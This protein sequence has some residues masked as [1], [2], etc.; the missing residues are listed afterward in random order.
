VADSFRKSFFSQP[1]SPLLATARAGNVIGGGDWSED[2]LIPD[3]VRAADAGTSLEIRSPHATRPWQHVLES[4]SGYL[5]LG[6]K[7]IEANRSFAAAWNFGPDRDGN[8]AVGEVLELLKKEWEGLHWHVTAEPQP[9]EAHLL[10]LDSSKARRDLGWQPVW[11][12]SQ[13]LKRT[14]EWYR[15]YMNEQRV[16]SREQLADYVDAA[17]RLQISWMD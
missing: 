14:A 4:I 13:G 11:G 6:Q 8:R 9:H 2:R 12:L 3:L 5:L 10:C 1:G 16:I 7:L 17:R 15:L